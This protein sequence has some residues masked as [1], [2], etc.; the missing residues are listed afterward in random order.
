MT[1]VRVLIALWALFILA[2][3]PRSDPADGSRQ[4]EIAA[5]A[6]GALVFLLAVFPLSK[7][8]GSR[9]RVNPVEAEDL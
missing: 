5:K 8:K 3:P 1:V 7:P 4:G 6:L 2:G 9:A